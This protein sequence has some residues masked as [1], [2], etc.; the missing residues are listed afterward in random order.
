[1]FTH[2]IISPP[3]Y[4]SNTDNKLY[5]MGTFFLKKEILIFSSNTSGFFHTDYT[6]INSI[7][8]ILTSEADLQAVASTVWLATSF[9]TKD[10][11]YSFLQRNHIKVSIKSPMK[12]HIQHLNLYI[13]AY[14]AGRWSCG[15][16]Y[17]VQIGSPTK[18]R[19]AYKFIFESET[20]QH[21][22]RT[23]ESCK[24]KH[25][26]MCLTSKISVDG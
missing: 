23:R 6:N 7:L 10:L 14:L 21:H 12:L 18:N 1:M 2:H 4:H 15:R 3:K 22:P 13:Q 20:W 16:L 11:T 9:S 24:M 17:G 8:I 25:A 26:C 5:F 19:R